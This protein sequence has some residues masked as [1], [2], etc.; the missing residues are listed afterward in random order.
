MILSAQRQHGGERERFTIWDTMEG[1]PNGEKG[2]LWC[3]Y[4]LWMAGGHLSVEGHDYTHM[5]MD[6]SGAFRRGTKRGGGWLTFRA[7]GVT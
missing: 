7:H 1:K 6:V 4:E 5:M 3:Q 2:N